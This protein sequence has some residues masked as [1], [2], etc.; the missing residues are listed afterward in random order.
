[1]TGRRS[2]LPSKTAVLLLAG[3][4]PLLLSTG[5]S[6]Q[7]NLRRKAGVTSGLAVHLGTTDGELEASLAVDG[8]MLVHGIA[9]ED[10]ALAAS[11]RTLQ[12]RGLYGLASV[13]KG[14]LDRLPYAD[15]LVNLLV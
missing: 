10:G 15:N 9:F 12:A 7:E 4:G 13:E 11:R 5:L 8:R 2:P 1:M 3:F 6:S 14:T